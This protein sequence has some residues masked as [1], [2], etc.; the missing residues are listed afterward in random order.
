MVV[1]ELPEKIY[2]AQAVPARLS[3]MGF[4]NSDVFPFGIDLRRG[5]I[6]LCF[7]PIAI[8]YRCANNSPEVARFAPTGCHASPMVAL[9]LLVGRRRS[10][11]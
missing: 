6:P 7:G 9:L 8:G 1:L 5:I 11:V 2:G 10:N 4:L 3:K